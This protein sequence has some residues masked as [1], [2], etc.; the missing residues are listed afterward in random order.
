MASNNQP[1]QSDQTG[2]VIPGLPEPVLP[3]PDW[4]KHVVFD[5]DVDIQTRK[6]ELAKLVVKRLPHLSIHFLLNERIP[7]WN[8]VGVKWSVLYDDPFF[9][10]V[11]YYFK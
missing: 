5:E 9:Q 6:R 10:Y 1:G 11:Y 2:W 8:F 3:S 7:D 4:P